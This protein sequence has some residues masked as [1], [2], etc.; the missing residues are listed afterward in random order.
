MSVNLVHAGSSPHTRGLRVGG[1]GVGAPARII[2]AHAGF[3][4]CSPGWRPG[5]TDHP[6]T[7]GVYVA[8]RLARELAGGSSPHTRGL[9]HRSSHRAVAD[10]IIPAHAG[11]TRPGG[12]RHPDGADHPR[13]RGVYAWAGRVS[14]RP[15]GSSPHTRGLRAGRWAGVGRGGIIPAHAGFTSSST[16]G[17]FGLQDHPRTRGVYVAAVAVPAF[18][19]GSSPH[20]RGLPVGGRGRGG[21]TGIIPAHAGFTKTSP[22]ALRR[23][24]D[25]PRTRGVYPSGPSPA[26]TLSGSSP[27]TRGLPV[28]RFS[29][30]EDAGIIP[31]HAGFT[32]SPPELSVPAADHP[33]TRGV[34][35]FNVLWSGWRDGSSPHTR[36][37]LCGGVLVAGS[38][39]IIPAHAGFTTLT[40]CPGACRTD[41]PRTRGVYSH[42]ASH[43][44]ARGG[45]SPHTRGLLRG[46]G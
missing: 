1:Q 2:P 26:S 9:L 29:E 42:A 39:R 17:I 24:R 4:C 36:G 13:T 23:M 30:D 19:L 35:N 21:P 18:K 32:T 14:V 8:R 34:Y 33:R 15:P 11:F 38:P 3:T 10:G 27:H 41:H 7:R 5:R 46:R 16:S 28:V 40:C 37:L 44:A 25:H 31:A 43:E 6:R 45:S 22:P 20:T 12:G